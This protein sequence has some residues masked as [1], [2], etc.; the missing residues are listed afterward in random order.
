MILITGASRGVGKYLFEEYSKS[1]NK[2][3]GTYNSTL[4]KNNIVDSSEKYF[5][6]L[7]YTSPSPRD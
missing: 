1:S 3:Y 4:P 2:V 5:N 6:C 7:L